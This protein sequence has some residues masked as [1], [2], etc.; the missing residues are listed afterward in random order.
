MIIDL[1][2]SLSLDLLYSVFL[3]EKIS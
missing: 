3:L 1:L 2:L